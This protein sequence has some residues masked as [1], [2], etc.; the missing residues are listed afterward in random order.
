M[1]L[2]VLLGLHNTLSV[3]LKYK[4]KTYAVNAQQEAYLRMEKKRLEQL[5]DEK[6]ATGSGISA[7][8]VIESK[9]TEPGIM[10]EKVEERFQLE[11]EKN[12]SYTSVLFQKASLWSVLF[13]VALSGYIY[14]A[15]RQYF[16]I[17]TVWLV[18]IG[19]IIVRRFFIISATFSFATSKLSSILS[20]VFVLLLLQPM[21]G[22]LR[23]NKS[24]TIEPYD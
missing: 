3:D 22:M 9:F 21:F 13:L 4:R 15:H 12:V 6:T 20:I 11:A 5:K 19:I 10:M 16:W 7:E 2:L 17:H 23:E 8:P 24:K 14:T 18:L 1:T